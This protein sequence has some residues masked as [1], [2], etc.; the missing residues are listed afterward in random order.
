[1]CDK[2]AS[3]NES[4]KT[5]AIGKK[6]WTSCQDGCLEAVEVFMKS[7]EDFFEKAC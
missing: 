6:S 7:K 3:L 1:M 4:L 5:R 2:N